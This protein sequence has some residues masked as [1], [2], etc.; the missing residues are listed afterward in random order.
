MRIRFV[1][2]FV[3]CAGGAAS[4]AP[5]VF[6]IEIE[7]IVDSATPL[8]NDPS[9]NFAT[10]EP[11]SI[12]AVDE[13]FLFANAAT[14]GFQNPSLN[15]LYFASDSGIELLTSTGDPPFK[16]GALFE[17]IYSNGGPTV[18]RARLN[19]PGGLT[20]S[21]WTHDATGVHHLLPFDAEL[22][23]GAGPASDLRYPRISGS[24]VLFVG[25]DGAG[26]PRIYRTSTDGA[27]IETVIGV[28]PRPGNPDDGFDLGDFQGD[29]FVFRTLAPN[30]GPGT[31]VYAGDLD[32]NTTEF[33]KIG[34][35]VPGHEGEEFFRFAGGT[36][37]PS[38]DNGRV[39]FV[40][41]GT[42][43]IDG[44]YTATITDNTLEVVVDDTMD[45]PNDNGMTRFFGAPSISGDNIAF[46][47]VGFDSR[48]V[49]AYVSMAGTIVDIIHK[50]ETLDGKIVDNVRGGSFGLNG[51]TLAFTIDFDDS[52]R[53]LYLATVIPAPGAGSVA[54]L[55]GV[56]A[57]R[58]RRR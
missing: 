22:P 44:V 41:Q 2:G 16:D 17:Q 19:A 20:S 55:G 28:S 18:F 9:L 38:M 12:V 35:P 46:I 56:W 1:L 58:R 45:L 6:T 50:G 48:G 14:G 5:P 15:G 54:M 3:L 30:F 52:S 25:T 32:G 33:A 7:R 51:N 31:G 24:D 39:A 29:Q 34:D 40:G 26:Q 53:G 42:N 10:I 4:A 27:P 47:G 36:S 43:G 11:S 37:H 13:G 23:D 21:I 57:C 8:P 49:A